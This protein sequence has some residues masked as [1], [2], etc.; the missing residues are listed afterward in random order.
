[1]DTFN[2][3]LNNFLTGCREIALEK[4]KT[5]DDYSKWIDK[6]KD[7]RTELEA[8]L[9]PEANEL[10]ASYIEAFAAMQSMEYNTV[11][12]CGLT[13]SM[14]IQKYFDDSTPE[15]KAFIEEFIQ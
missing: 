8:L 1:M 6:Q 4:L 5:N 12:M 9:S 15:Y 2:E 3:I 13:T 11:F 14:K 7:L 10:L